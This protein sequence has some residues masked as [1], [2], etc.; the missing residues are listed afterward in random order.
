[1]RA[2]IAA[3]TT[4]AGKPTEYQLELYP[5]GDMPRELL[6]QILREIGFDARTSMNENIVIQP[7]RK[8]AKNT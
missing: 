6:C 7:P 8:E 5:D 2:S 3:R 4:I 1:M